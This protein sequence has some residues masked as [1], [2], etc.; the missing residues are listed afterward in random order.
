MPILDSRLSL[1][2]TLVYE[3]RYSGLAQGIEEVMGQNR[4]SLARMRFG[5]ELLANIRQATVKD[6]LATQRTDKVI[7]KITYVLLVKIV[8]D[9]PINSPNFYR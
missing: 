7:A 1:N 5:V 6:S 2:P 3:S 9:E 4:V 8:T